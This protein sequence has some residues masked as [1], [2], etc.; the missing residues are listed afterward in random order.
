MI[1]DKDFAFSIENRYIDR[2]EVVATTIDCDRYI[3]DY[4]DRERFIALC[5]ECGNYGK[6]WSCPPY[7]D[8]SIEDLSKFKSCYIIGQKIIIKEEMRSLSTQTDDLTTVISDIL[9]PVRE[10]TDPLLRDLES[11]IEGS[12]VFFA[13]SCALCKR[14][15]C[16]RIIGEKC[17]YP[18]KIR[19]SLE[20]V[21]FDIGCT[22]SQ[23]I[24]SE[25]KWATKDTLPEYYLLISAIFTRRLPSTR[26]FR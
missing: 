5:K 10:L 6:N 4:R 20:S 2:I 26:G 12:R 13:G 14:G 8:S 7:A 23:L 17:R 19:P 25:L 15:E 1:S 24:K 9:L 16:S 21:G 11:K 3:A 22:A 18:D